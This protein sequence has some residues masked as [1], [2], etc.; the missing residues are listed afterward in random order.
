MERAKSM[1][2]V[3]SAPRPG[4]SGQRANI[5]PHA[6]GL[7]I[8]STTKRA[9]PANLAPST[10]RHTLTH[11]P[12][13]IRQSPGW[14]WQEKQALHHIAQS[15]PASKRATARSIYLALTE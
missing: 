13:N 14:L 3:A 7:H 10:P 6:V 9:I 11:A 12:R 15:F 4:E 1:F 2:P 8:T 5:Y